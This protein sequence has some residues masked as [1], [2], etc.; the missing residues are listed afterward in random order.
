ME[1]YPNKE[2]T[3]KSEIC[4]G[5]ADM[6]KKMGFTVYCEMKKDLVMRKHLSNP[7][8][9]RGVTHSHRPVRDVT[10]GYATDA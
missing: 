8:H 3:D 7:Y 1:A 2:V 6:Y 4:V 9:P 10:D 5:Y